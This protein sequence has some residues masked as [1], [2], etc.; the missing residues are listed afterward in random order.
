MLFTWWRSA[1]A[2]GTI[3]VV[4]LR[5]FSRLRR[6]PVARID[7][8]PLRTPEDATELGLIIGATGNEETPWNAIAIK[9]LKDNHIATGANEGATPA[10]GAA[11]KPAGRVAGQRPD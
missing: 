3:R 9:N 11:G 5:R 6:Q 7:P 2:S 8:D 10:P 4:G 1:R